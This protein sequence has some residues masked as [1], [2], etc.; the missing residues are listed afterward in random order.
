LTDSVRKYACGKV[1]R[2]LVPGTVKVYRMEGFGAL[3]MGVHRFH[4]TG[5]EDTE[6][7]EEGKFIYLWQYN[8]GTWR[9]TRLIIYDYH[10]APK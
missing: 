10:P 5:H 8:D 3:G 4:H 9:I 7:V 6:P 1:T 2:E